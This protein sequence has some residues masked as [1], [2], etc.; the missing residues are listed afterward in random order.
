MSEDKNP[1]AAPAPAHRADHDHPLNAVAGVLA[2]SAVEELARPLREL[3]QQLASLVDSLEQHARGSEGPSPY[4][5]T[6]LQSLRQG[7]AEAYLLSRETAR[8]ADE[9][10]QVMGESAIDPEVRSVDVNRHI[11]AALALVRSR[12]SDKTELFVDLGTVPPVCAVPGELSLMVAKLLLCCADSTVN[13]PGSAV[14]VQTRHEPET[15]PPSVIV[16]I[17]DNGDG[18]P[19]G[20]RSAQASLAPIMERLGGSYDGVAE[21][22]QGSAFECWFPVARTPASA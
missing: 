15:E 10:S 18:N 8:I 3:R 7:V 21:P 13:R 12:F 2:S 16:L 9:L 20:A 1:S 14:S 6:S 17:A 5:W 22:G 11:E 19:D 4:P